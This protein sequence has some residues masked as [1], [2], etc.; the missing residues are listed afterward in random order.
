MILF[1][2]SVKRSRVNAFISALAFLCFTTAQ[3]APACLDRNGR[4]LPIDDQTVLKLKVSTPNQF[5]SRAHIS[6]TIETI[7]PIK[8]GHDHFQVKIGPKPD[9]TIE[10]IYNRSFGPLDPLIPGQTVE[11]CGDYI[12]STAP[13]T[14]Y[15][16][17][18]DGAILHWVHRSNNT[19]KHKS[20]YVIMN[21]KVLGQGAGTGN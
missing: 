17:S 9:D 12:T 5:L 2:N 18:P 16:P 20:G 13:T 21:G 19:G 6:G 3:A 4:D 1:K 7:Y 11:A 10:V 15:E 14:N 8:N